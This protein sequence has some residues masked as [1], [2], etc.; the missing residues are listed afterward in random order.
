MNYYAI[1]V[2][3]GGEEKYIRLFR[4]LHPDFAAEIHFPRRQIDERRRG[5]IVRRTAGIFPGY[6]FVEAGEELFLTRRWDFRRTDGF[7]RFLRSNRNIRPL[8]GRDLEVVLH[9]IRKA[10]PVAGTSKVY[11]NENARVVVVDGPLLGLEGKIVKVDK[12]KGRAKIKLDLYD[13]SFSIDLAFEIIQPAA[14]RGQA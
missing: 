5:V 12:R 1:Q 14:V 13:D 3:T 11:F 9:F 6:I 2:K 4:S 8:Q 10:G 7:F